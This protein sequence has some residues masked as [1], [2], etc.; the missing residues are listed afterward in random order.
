MKY[1]GLLLVNLLCLSSA[2]AQVAP[3]CKGATDADGDGVADCIDKC[4]AS[5]PGETIGPNGCPVYCAFSTEP[6]YRFSTGSSEL[7]SETLANLQESLRILKRYEDIRIK[8]H[9]HSD[10]CLGEEM[11]QEV[12][13]QRAKAVEK[14]LLENGVNSSRITEVRG[15]GSTR[16]MEPVPPGECATST[17]N[18]A[19]V[20]VDN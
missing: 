17:S 14:Y 7:T 13:L 5:K 6:S 20:N 1:L 15:Y 10:S 2:M 8:V 16:P 19:E 18:R 11:S 4:P 3:A 12:S 9:G